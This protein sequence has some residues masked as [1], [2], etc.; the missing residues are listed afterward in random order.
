MRAG[1]IPEKDK[2]L[3]VEAVVT[4]MCRGILRFSTKAGRIMF[5]V[6]GWSGKWSVRHRPRVQKWR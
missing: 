1:I 3:V 6:I 2:V 4:L 5:W